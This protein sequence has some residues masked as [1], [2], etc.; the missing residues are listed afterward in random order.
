MFGE[1]KIY[2]G[3]RWRLKQYRNGVIV[4][5]RKVLPSNG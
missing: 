4:V 5:D 2:Y 3:A 1:K